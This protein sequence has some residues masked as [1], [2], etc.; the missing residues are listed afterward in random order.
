MG[1][2]LNVVGRGRMGR[3]AT[4]MKSSRNQFNSFLSDLHHRKVEKKGMFSPMNLAMQ[5][6]FKRTRKYGIIAK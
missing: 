1:D 3:S 2:F 5:R 6:H 4:N